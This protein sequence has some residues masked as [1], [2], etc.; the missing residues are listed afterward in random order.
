[1]PLNFEA[2]ELAQLTSELQEVSTAITTTITTAIAP[3]AD[4][5][6]KAAAAGEL[7]NSVGETITDLA[8]GQEGIFTKIKQIQTFAQQKV[9]LGINFYNSVLDTINQV[10]VIIDQLSEP[11][12][13]IS[14]LQQ[15]ALNIVSQSILNDP[16]SANALATIANLSAA[17]QSAGPA[18]ERIIDNLQ[19][20]IEDP[21]NTPLDVCNDIPNLIKIGETFVEFPSKALQADPTKTLENIQETIVKEYET[22][23]DN[24]ST[25]SEEK[26][27]EVFEQTIPTAP[28]YPL[29]DVTTDIAISGRVPIS[30]ATNL[31]PGTANQAALIQAAKPATATSPAVPGTS[32]S[33][34][35]ETN[36]NTPPPPSLANPFPEGKQFVAADFAPSKYAKNIASKVNSLHPSVRGRFAAGVQDYIRTNYPSRDVNV[37]EGYRSPER[38]AKLAASGIK[39]APAG[40]SWHNY[41]CACD[42]T[43]YVEGK[44]DDGRR[45]PGEYTGLARQ[46]MQKYGLINDLKGD[47]GHFYPS[48]FGAG[49]PKA[50]REKQI[51][52]T[53]YASSKGL[54][55]T[56]ETQVAAVTSSSSEKPTTAEGGAIVT[57]KGDTTT[58]DIRTVQRSA[59]DKAISDALAQGKSNS[60][61]ERLGEIA[62]NRAGANALRNLG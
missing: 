31:G 50:V 12:L 61:A 15:E 43:I 25:L 18:A 38:S 59:R 13:L 52:I 44:W 42:L 48:A 16:T 4:A 36:K 9:M 8:C 33:A 17:Y 47:S 1:M 24:A 10:Q 11:D 28:K 32:P 26:L 3:V 20:F 21:L 55:S 34:V 5:I 7:A 19:Q 54:I 27:K 62:G 49:V 14:L 51:D 6:N 60:E 22:I 35:I 40:K 56:Q 53:A 37:T 45:G 29:P 58:I 57:K 46:S 23:F 41:G 39:A 2:I 30:I